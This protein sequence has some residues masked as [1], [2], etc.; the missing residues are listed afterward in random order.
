MATKSNRMQ[1]KVAGHTFCQK[2]LQRRQMKAKQKGGAERNKNSKR[3]GER[4][5]GH[6]STWTG[7]RG[8]RGGREGGEGSK[9]ERTRGADRNH[10]R[11]HYQLHAQ[12]D[13]AAGHR[14][15]SGKQEEGK[16]KR[17]ANE[18]KIRIKLQFTSNPFAPI[19]THT[20]AH[21]YTH[22]HKQQSYK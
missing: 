5:K 9:V 2:F 1:H 20:L 14:N 19:C 7:A 12:Q 16:E 3:Y 13:T 18:M 21:P 4:G 17:K 8:A 11:D 6:P 10:N 15:R 22:T